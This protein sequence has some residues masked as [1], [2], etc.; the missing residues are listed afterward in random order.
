MAKTASEELAGGGVRGSVEGEKVLGY[1]GGGRGDTK[2]VIE[3]LGGVGEVGGV[4]K[5]VDVVK[6][7]GKGKGR[8]ETSC[9]YDACTGVD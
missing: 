8:G 7:L 2:G 4:R 3:G 9:K 1:V 5:D 6:E